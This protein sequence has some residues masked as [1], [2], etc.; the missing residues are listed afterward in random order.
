MQMD[1]ESLFMFI[2]KVSF[3]LDD[4]VLYLDTHPTDQCALE[5][6]DK[7]RRLRK[8][9]MEEYTNCFGPLTDEDV[10]VENY[11]TWIESPWPWEREC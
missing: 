5:Y 7:C 4:C 1:R 6:Y 8:Q 2:T 11:W 3:A 10:K 9:A